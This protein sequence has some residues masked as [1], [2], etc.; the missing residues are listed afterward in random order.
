[1]AGQRHVTKKG[2]RIDGG[3]YIAAELA[4][5]IGAQVEV[6]HDPADLGRVF[7]YDM[8]GGFVCAAEDPERTG[9]DR[10]AVAAAAKALARRDI[11][12][13]RGRLRQAAKAI[14]AGARLAEAIM[15]AAAASA[16]T[17]LPFPRAAQAHSTEAL[18]EHGRAVRA[19]DARPAPER[20][21]EDAARQRWNAELAARRAAEAS[22]GNDRAQADARIARAWAVR[23]ALHAGTPTEPEEAAWFGGYRETGEWRQALRVRGIDPKTDQP[24]NDEESTA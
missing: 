5:H 6:R 16:A 22:T 4:L 15:D 10:E 8:D 19:D 24:I 9:L 14:P 1:M 3:L 21:A 2:L 23:A 20:S 13:N 12:D 17:I 7:V 18:A 11:T